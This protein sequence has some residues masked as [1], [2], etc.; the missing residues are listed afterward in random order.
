MKFDRYCIPKHQAEPASPQRRRAAERAVR[1]DADAVPLFPE[2]RRYSCVDDRLA[3]GDAWRK[4]FRTRMRA[5]RAHDWRRVRAEMRALNPITR[6]GLLRWWDAWLS[7]RNPLYLI[8]AIH[9]IRTH[10]W[11]PWGNLRHHRQLV[12]AGARRRAMEGVHA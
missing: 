3:E 7:D 10:C 1:R 5:S 12:L 8:S 11:S 2:L 6:A 4:E 9:K